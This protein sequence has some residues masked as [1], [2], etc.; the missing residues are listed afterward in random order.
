LALF[1]MIPFAIFDGAK[2]LRWNK[3]VYG[4]MVAVSFILLNVPPFIPK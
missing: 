3:V 1:N 4:A 2:I